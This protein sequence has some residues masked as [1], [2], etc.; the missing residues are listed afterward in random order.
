MTVQP[1][2][3][4]A[5]L[6]PA[7]DRRNPYIGPRPYADDERERRLF[8]GRDRESADLLS[9][10]LAERLVLFYAPSGAGKSSLINARLLP[11]LRDESFAILGKV[12]VGGQLPDTLAHDAIANVY[13]FN[14][15]RDLDQGRSDF[16]ALATQR[17]PAFLAAQ[18][19]DPD[20]PDRILIIDQFEELF[21]TYAD[22]WEK[23]EDF[24]RQLGQALADD[25]HLWMMLTMRE[26]YIAELD[27]YTRLLPNRLRVRYRLQYMD[28][29]AALEAVKQPAAL[30]RRPFEPGV[31]ETLVNNLRQMT[32]GDAPDAPARL[33][34]TI[35]PVQLQVVCMQLWESLAERPGETITAA[36]VASL[37]RGAGLGEFVNHALA[38][39]YEQ[40]LAAVITAAAGR[41]SQRELRDW[42]SHTL[43]TR[44][45][46]RNLIYQSDDETGGL[47]NDV[48][49]ELE[50]RFLLRGETRSGG[51]WV[52][53]VHDRLVAP[54][55]DANEQW[56]RRYPLVIAADVWNS[57]RRAALLL[58]GQ[59][60]ADAQ[61][62]IR[63]RRQCRGCPSSRN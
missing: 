13:L 48:V 14:L 39:F 18:P 43:I 4:S 3:D 56:R 26:D 57:E 31:A 44:D 33:G 50:R 21:T 23:R 52:E 12:R 11:A 40:T 29:A 24:F 34:E 46:T 7:T 9:L 19:T 22:Q 55:R 53:L 63:D 27:P 61:M 35:E 5:A 62:C 15:L 41:V 17:L 51:R 25:P 60:L 38:N 16:P 2:G 49:L 36:D 6:T 59:A 32:P 37:G 30:A 45:G 28:A 20:R 47:P 58:T 54:I 10:V 8:F 1:N 42:F